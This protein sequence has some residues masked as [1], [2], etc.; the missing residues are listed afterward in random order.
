LKIIPEVQNE[1]IGKR[2]PWQT[3]DRLTVIKDLRN[4]LGVAG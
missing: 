4:E 3:R 1:P 2:K